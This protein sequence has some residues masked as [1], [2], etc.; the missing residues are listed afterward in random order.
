MRFFSK[1]LTKQEDNLTW[2]RL[3]KSIIDVC[4]FIEKLN[5]DNKQS[6]LFEIALNVEEVCKM[7]GGTINNAKLIT[8]GQDSCVI[9]CNGKIIKITGL[10]YDDMLL[11]EYVSR[12]DSI[13]VPLYEKNFCANVYDMNLFVTVLLFDK[14]DTKKVSWYETEQMYIK[15]REAGYIWSD[16]RPE[17]IGRDENGQLKLI[18]YGQIIYINDKSEYF[19]KKEIEVNENRYPTFARAYN[20]YIADMKSERRVR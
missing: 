14:L 20:D 9:E 2:D 3:L 1:I 19:R 4:P 11:S 8:V 15:L 17:N 7:V 10:F 12:C 13:I 18:D 16:P 5:T 6:L